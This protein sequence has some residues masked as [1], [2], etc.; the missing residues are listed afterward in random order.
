M[1]KFFYFLVISILTTLPSLAQNEGISFQGLA[2]N[3]AGEV[4][5]SHKISLRLSILLNSVTGEVVYTE[6][7]E[8]TT[9][10]QGIFAVVVG[11][12]TANSKTGNFS[13]IDWRTTAKFIKVEMDT[14]AGS[15]FTVMGTS[16]LQPVPFAYYAYGVD[17]ENVQGI[18][19]VGSGGTGV[20]SLAELKTRLGVDQ[21]NNTTDANKPLS[22]AATTA[23]ATKVDKVIGKELS[24]NDFSTAEKAKLAAI[25]GTNTGDQDL[26]AYAT[27]TQLAT[28]ANASDVTASLSTK[29]DKE[30]GK[31]LSSND[32]TTA[33]KI[34]LA[35]ITA[36]GT[37]PAGPAGPAGATGPQGPIGL[38]GPAGA[39]GPAGPQGPIG[40]SGPAG[41]TGP[42]GATGPQGPIGLT[43]PAGPTG[44][45]GPQGPIGLSGAAGATGPQGPIG[46]TGATGA[47]GATGPAGPQGATGLL[48][49]GTAAGNTPYWNGLEWVVNSSNLFN[50]GSNLGIGTA[51]PTEKLDIVG[52]VK[53][54]G[55]LTSGTVTYPNT[56]GTANQVLTTTGTG[57]LTWS[58]PSGGAITVGAISNSATPNGASVTSGVLN[59]APADATNGGIVTTGAQ[60]FAG[61]KTFTN[62]ATFGTDITV[63][64]LTVGGSTTFG[65]TAVGYLALKQVQA[66]SYN[67]GSWNTAIGHASMYGNTTGNFN[68][69]IGRSALTNNTTGSYNTTIGFHSGSSLRTVGSA[70]GTENT[71][72]GNSSGAGITTGSYNTILGSQ[73]YTIVSGAQVGIGITTGSNNT[74]I[75]GRIF[76]LT[77]T[78]SNNIILADGAGNIR[79]QYDGTTGWTLGTIAS[80]TWSGTTISAAKGG[81]GLTSPGASGNVLTSDGTNWVSTTPAVSG[82]SNLAYSGTGATNGGSISGTTLTLTAADATNPGLISTGA[83]TI[84]GAKTFSSTIVGSIS[85]NAATVTNGVYT[86]NK[87]SALSATTSSELA[88]VISDE[89]GSGALVFATSPTLVTPTLGAATATSVAFAGSTS[90]TATISAPAV[91]GTTAITLP[92]ASGTLATVAGTETL[93]NKTLTSPI[94]TTPNLGTPTSLTLTSA[95]GLPLETGVTGTLPLANGGTG[96]TTKAAAF[97]ALSPMT[98]SGDMIYGGSSGA[99]TVLAKGT[100]GQFLSLTSGAPAWTSIPT[101]TASATGY[102]A[103]ADWSTFNTKQAAYT[104]LTTIGSLSNGSGFLKNDGSGVFTYA[105]PSTSEISGLGTGVATWLATPSSANFAGAIT[106]E[107]GTGSVVL[108]TSPTLVT[109]VLGVATGTSLSVSGQLTSTVATGTAPLVVT[110]TTP[111]ANLNIGGNAA[112]ATTATN[113][114]GG[115]SGSIPYQTAAATTAMLAKGT[116]GQVLTLVSGNPSWASPAGVTSVGSISASSTANGASITSGVLNLAPADGTNGGVVTTS[117]QTFAGAKTFNSDLTVNGLTIGKGVNSLTENTALGVNAL[118]GNNSGDGAN[119]AIGH[120]SLRANTSGT[121]NTGIGSYALNAN[122]SGTRNAAF[123][124][125]AIQANSTGNNNSGFGYGTLYAT[126]AS[127]NSAFGYLAGYNI[128]TGAKNIFIGSLAGNSIS[129]GTTANSTGLNSVLI[130]YDVRPLANGDNNEIV[131]SGYN[132]TAGTVGLGSNTTLIGNSATTD[133]RIMGAL[134]L[135][136][137]IASTSTTTGALKVSGGAGIAGN[138][139]IGGTLSIAGGT[140]AAGDVLTSDANGLATWLAP[141]GITALAAIG[142]TANP[143]GA[144]ISGSTLNL[145]PASA[146]F[147]GVVTTGT[148]TFAGAKTFSSDLKVNDLTVGKGAASFTTLLGQE[149]GAALTSSGT[150]NVAV[151][152]QALTANTS[153]TGN[154]AVGSIAGTS[155]TTGASNVALGSQALRNATSGFSNTAIGAG[156]LSALTDAS[157]NIGI[158]SSSGSKLT[159]GAYNI[160]IG[161][162][163]GTNIGSGSVGNTTGNY[164][165][166]IGTQTR[167]AADGETNQIVIAG[168]GDG[169]TTVGLGSNTTLIGSSGTTTA[170][171]M[172]ALTL[173]NTTASTSSTTGALKVSGGAGI[174]GNVYIGGTLSIAGGTPAAG[175]VLTSDANGLATWAAPSGVSSIGSISASSTP[176]GASIT[177]GVL[178]LAPASVNH[179]GV[180]TTGTQTFAGSKTFN[181][182]LKVNDL[183]VGKGAANFTT[184]L[185]LEA[186]AALLS[187]GTHNVAVGYQ[188]L[189]AN[190]GGTDNVAVGNIAGTTLTTGTGNV[191]LGSQALRSATTGGSNNAIGNGALGAVTTASNNIGIGTI[192]GSRLTT[193]ANNIHIGSSAGTYFGTGY[194]SNTTGLN[195]VLIGFDVRPNGNAETNQIVISGYNGSTGTVGNGSNT[196][197]IGNSS[198]IQTYLPSG[199]TMGNSLGSKDATLTLNPNSTSAQ[200]GAEGGQ[201][202]FKKSVLTS[203]YDWFID[204]YADAYGARLRFLPGRTN[205]ESYGMAISEEGYIGMG[206]IPTSSYRLNVSGTVGATGYVTTSDLRLKTNISSLSSAMNT[207]NLLIPVSYDK[208]VSL[209]DSV[210]SKQ[211]FGFIAQEVQKVLPQLVTEGKDKDHLLSLDYISI[212]PLLTKAMQEQDVVIKNTQLENKQLKAQLEEQ[213]RR[214]EEIEKLVQQLIKS[215]N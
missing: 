179:G 146:N 2:R 19:P 45:T 112:T 49:S 87:L 26:S 99:A 122:T 24:T 138:V 183:T 123:G 10:P 32:Y 178:N 167:P 142:S 186:G 169:I 207:L 29:V 84:A 37:G 86:T 23:L 69:A 53:T 52:N 31:G 75:G 1:K 15:N 34:K 89:T 68:T 12:G 40:L 110:S 177:S 137:T 64:G 171:I 196:T 147:G 85:G 209:T 44:A 77:P 163:A 92:A 181:S 51:N 66:G 62:A 3:A 20:A 56:H 211:E 187:S 176:N 190:T 126:T 188:A 55:T 93:T 43:G 148:Q 144:S 11:D 184:L 212:I 214:L 175:E 47:T 21:V 7:R 117:A 70:F 202:N 182:D 174:A 91:A 166:M 79:A 215:N 128:T 100:D 18:V 208:K 30:I 170:R 28:K 83:Q 111:V 168:G 213:N 22:T 57:A 139:H 104:N 4:I 116:N 59:L 33:E 72:I 60:T 48:S 78:L 74:I 42:V 95:T 54:S 82:V 152:Y 198:T 195:S 154:V 131:I 63:N 14:N 67:A 150:N 118:S 127:D 172:G 39:T 145:Q 81:T 65:N 155:L 159:T 102:L 157:G 9:N 25:T 140:P 109:P 38:T 103:S 162:S 164:S 17:A 149:A 135:P 94:L 197:T 106:D 46:L 151:G 189:K 61:A 58:A 13:T 101:A 88:G 105:N 173:P 113:I 73:T 180:V 204:Q 160:N 141:A 8:T 153:G 97:N 132:G 90:G 203:T 115:A 199:L 16:K 133:T 124:T 210:Y 121:Y 76:G 191:A 6:T 201:L 98:A 136:S 185:G 50:N 158:G 114:A 156:S 5:V 125:M 134:T 107:T 193:G 129:T 108:A 71:F 200:G 192:S 35:S 206:S 143:N 130:G 80:G 27:N 194:D 165:I 161:S 205:P 96:A 120:S 36:G 41:A 119:T